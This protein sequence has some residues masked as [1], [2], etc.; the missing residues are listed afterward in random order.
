MSRTKLLW[1]AVLALAALSCGGTT[2]YVRARTDLGAIRAVAILPFENLANDRLGSERVERIFFTEVLATEAF[3]VVEPGL[4]ARTLRR[5]Q[6]DPANLTADDFKRLGKALDAQALFL[7]SVLEYDEGR[8]GPAPSPRVK[9]QF[10]LVDAETGT[11]LW[12]V[13]RTA[14]GAGVA[15]RLF[16]I[17]GRSAAT[18]A[19]GIVREELSRLL[20]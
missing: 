12:S 8:G 5:D 11:T 1:P 3:S 16:G 7:G 6:V 19:E 2:R 15:A 13:A 17:G 20:R 4:V 10:R 14:G 9:L 18:V